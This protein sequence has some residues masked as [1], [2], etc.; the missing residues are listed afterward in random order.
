[1]NQ[2]RLTLALLMPLLLANAIAWYL[3]PKPWVA[4]VW[5]ALLPIAWWAMRR[6]A[7]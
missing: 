1:M 3:G 2:V 4:I 5:I 6:A 7:P